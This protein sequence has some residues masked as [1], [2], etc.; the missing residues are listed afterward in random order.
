MA[1]LDIE[2]LANEHRRGTDG[3]TGTTATNSLSYSISLSGTTAIVNSHLAPTAAFTQNPDMD[4]QGE[5]LKELIEESAGGNRTEFVEATR[6]ATALMGD[7]I[8]TNLFML[9]FAYQKG[10]VPVSEASILEA[11]ELNGVAVDMN[12][13]A[14]IWGRRAAHDPAAVRR[15]ALPEGA[16]AKTPASAISPG[17]CRPCVTRPRWSRP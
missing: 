7:A 10:F 8:A 9:G 6:I 3:N 2:A 12:K 15:I 13:R 16:P 4:F 11:I 5:R 17:P 1:S 14:F